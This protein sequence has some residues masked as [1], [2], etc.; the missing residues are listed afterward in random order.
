MVVS[1]KKWMDVEGPLDIERP[2]GEDEKGRKGEIEMN[3]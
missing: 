1:G 2:M 3:Q